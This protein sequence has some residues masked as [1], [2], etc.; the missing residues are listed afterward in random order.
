MEKQEI[1]QQ[2]KILLVKLFEIDEADIKPES[3]LYEELELDSIDA[4]DL[5]VHL[6]KVTG[7]KIMPEMFKSVRTVQDVVDAVDNLLNTKS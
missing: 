6:Q 5:V 4:V 2:I 1:Y 7:K 3:R